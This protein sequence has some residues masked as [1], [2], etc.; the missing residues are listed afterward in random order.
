[1]FE[2]VMLSQK[3]M[4]EKGASAPA[5]TPAAPAPASSAAPSSSSG[6]AGSNGGGSNSMASSGGSN[7]AGMATTTPTSTPT[8]TTPTTA[9]VT[10]G[11]TEELKNITSISSKPKDGSAGGNG[12]VT[13]LTLDPT[14]GATFQVGTTGSKV[15]IDK[16]GIS[17][18]P[19]GANNTGG[20]NPFADTASI[21]IKAGA[22]PADPKSLDSLDPNNGPSIEFSAKKTSDGKST[23]AQEKSPV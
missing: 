5:P 16:E 21:T 1:M 14:D 20:A 15:K 22:K 6:G 23:L 4:Y 3:Q 18:T 19:Q 10:I 9:V 11:T 12:E 17:L 8:T 2:K 13:K 7:G